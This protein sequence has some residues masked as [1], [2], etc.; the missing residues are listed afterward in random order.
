MDPLEVRKILGDT[1]TMSKW[2]LGY[3]VNM[4]LWDLHLHGLGSIEVEDV[5]V[6]RN[7]DLSE[8]KVGVMFSVKTLLLSGRYNMSA[9]PS[10][11]WL[12]SNISSE[13]DRDMSISLDNVTIGAEVGVGL[14]SV[15]TSGAHVKCV[16]CDQL[17]TK[18]YKQLIQGN[19]FSSSIRRHRLPV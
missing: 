4:Q 14:G 16:M 18:H 10:M 13:G 2:L 5:M 9:V 3:D 8:V 11:T 7:N 12:L 17:K 15:C 1:V 19:T 6:E